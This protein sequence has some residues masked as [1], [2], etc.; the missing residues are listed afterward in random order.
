MVNNLPLITATHLTHLRLSVRQ[1]RSRQPI[2]LSTRQ[3]TGTQPPTT[4]RRR[5]VSHQTRRAHNAQIQGSMPMRI[6]IPVRSLR[7]AT[8]S[9]PAPRHRQIRVTLRHKRPLIVPPTH[10]PSGCRSAAATHRATL[11]PS[12]LIP[13][14]R[15]RGRKPLKP[16]RQR[17]RTLRRQI[18]AQIRRRE[19]VHVPRFPKRRRHRH[20]LGRVAFLEHL[21]L[22]HAHAACPFTFALPTTWRDM[23][24]HLNTSRSARK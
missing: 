11:H 6:A 1:L 24:S 10:P 17:P 3:M 22:L 7:T 9:P 4:R 18:H 19:Q 14:N 20:P 2:R 8:L 5:A 13:G 16:L 12:N 15:L 21:H 23:T